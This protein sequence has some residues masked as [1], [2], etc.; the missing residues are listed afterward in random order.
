MEEKPVWHFLSRGFGE[1][2]GFSNGSLAEFKG[3]PLKAL[4][5][6]ICQNSLDAADGSGRPVV[7]EFEA[8]YIPIGDFPGMSGPQSIR[9]IIN[10][11][12]RY[13]SKKGDVNTITFLNRA[14]EHLK[15][16]GGQICVL[17]VSD[18]H[19]TGVSGAFSEEDITAWG[20]LVKGNAFSVKTDA[21]NAA[22]SYGIGKAAPFVSSYFQTVFYRTLDQENVRAA[23]GVARLMAHES[24]DPVPPG[25]DPVRR[26]VG[27][28][29]ADASGKPA[30]GFDE[31]DRLNLRGEHGTDLF[32]PGFIW[33]DSAEKWVDDIFREVA[34]NFLYSIWSG[35]LEVRIQKRALTR[36]NLGDMLET[37]GSRDAK[38]FY[39]VIFARADNPNLA[40]ASRDFHALGTLRLRLLY[41]N[42]LNKKLLVVRNSGMRIAR[43]KGLPR[44]ISYAGFLELQGDDLNSFFRA[45]ENPSHD[46]WEPRRHGNPDLARRYKED[47][48]SWV[49]KQITEKLI[50]ISGDESVVDMGNCFNTAEDGTDPA[51]EA[52]TEQSEPLRTETYIPQLPRSG[53]ISIRDE[54]RASPTRRAPGRADPN[55]TATGHR[56]RTG[57]QG[58][59]RPTGRRIMPDPAGPDAYYAGDGGNPREVWVN[60]RIISLGGGQNRLIFS[61]EEDIALGRMEVVTRGENGRSMMLSVKSVSGGN[62]RAEDGRI[63]IQDVP[64][65]TRQTLEF[66]LQD[67]SSFAQGVRAYGD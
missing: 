28:F 31:L 58:G 41:E 54:G 10:A 63:V 32:I 46:A 56:R 37:I 50:A 21:K 18:Y 51:G 52:I 62:A 44:T 16:A 55:G 11:C 38:L 3:D 40:E 2:E 60:A 22:G 13:W 39:R 59:G 5:R 24:I 47:L 14:R 35:K 19:T 7:V 23:L 27:Y 61:A 66:A 15:A 67:K 49:V 8:R 29:G 34:D 6:E 53:K 26:S 36:K 1:T 33:A 30:K 42:E 9:E 25:E 65:N 57:T 12:Y 48:E 43:I 64:A 45:M 20:S 17:R 4:A